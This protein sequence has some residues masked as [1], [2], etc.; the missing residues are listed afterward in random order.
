MNV[1]QPENA[2]PENLQIDT[3]RGQQNTYLEVSRS[4][5]AIPENQQIEVLS[6]FHSPYL[7]VSQPKNTIP[8]H[9]FYDHHAVCLALSGSVA[10]CVSYISRPEKPLLIISKVNPL[11]DDTVH[12]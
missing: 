10:L 6:R 8:V 3:V 9:H 1:T 7:N 5:N 11:L 4:E 2:I 12:I